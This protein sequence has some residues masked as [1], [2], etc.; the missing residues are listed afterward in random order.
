MKKNLCYALELPYFPDSGDENDD[1]F[2]VD[3][4]CKKLR[5]VQAERRK[6]PVITVEGM[7]LGQHLD[8]LESLE[9]EELAKV[10]SLNDF[11]LAIDKEIDPIKLYRYYR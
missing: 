11:E 6:N 1:D 9:P 10:A 4:L 2:P 3:E 8:Y 7:K 5:I